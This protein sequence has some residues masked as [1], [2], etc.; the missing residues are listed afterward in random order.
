MK[1]LEKKIGEV[2]EIKWKYKKNNK[3]NISFM[4]LLRQIIKEL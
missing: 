3:K 2:V 4:L 1:E